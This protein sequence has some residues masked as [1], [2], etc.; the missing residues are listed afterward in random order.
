MR[1]KQR[2]K[3]C[4]VPGEVRSGETTL[5]LVGCALNLVFLPSTVGNHCMVISMAVGSKDVIIFSFCIGL[6]GQDKEWI[7]G[8]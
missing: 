4:K 8:M 7:M 2:A 5:G 1:L 6:S 3:K